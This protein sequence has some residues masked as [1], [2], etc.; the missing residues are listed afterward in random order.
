MLAHRKASTQLTEPPLGAHQDAADLTAGNAGHLGDLFLAHAIEAGHHQNLQ[1]GGRH[2]RRQPVE[3]LARGHH[4]LGPARPAGGVGPFGRAHLHP[5]AAPAQVI[6]GQAG[7]GQVQPAQPG[8]HRLVHHRAGAE[9]KE[10]LL[11]DVGRF[12][13]VSEHAGALGPDDREVLLEEV[14]EF[15]PGHR[16]HPWPAP[17]LIERTDPQKRTAAGANGDGRRDQAVCSSSRPARG[18]LPAPARGIS[19]RAIGVTPARV[20]VACS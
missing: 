1:L 13:A 11:G 2:L 14:I 3:R 18:V 17:R 7:A 8:R 5:Q 12:F 19:L 20:G 15:V 16:E 6:D 4:L 9:A 10:G